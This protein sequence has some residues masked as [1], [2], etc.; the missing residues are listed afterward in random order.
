MTTA[1]NDVRRLEAELRDAKAALTR[2]G[3]TGVYYSLR[4]ANNRAEAAEA[5]LRN[6][7]EA[8][9]EIAA[10]HDGNQPAALNMPELDYARHTIRQMNQ[11]ARKALAGGKQCGWP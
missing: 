5:V 7:R 4:E 8:L 1:E 3:D 10:T 9:E 6:W 11:V 2:Y